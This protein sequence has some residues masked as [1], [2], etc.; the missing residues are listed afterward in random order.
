MVFGIH[1]TCNERSCASPTH[2][3]KHAPLLLIYALIVYSYIKYHKYSKNSCTF[4][5][6][7]ISFEIRRRYDLLCCLLVKLEQSL[8]CR[9]F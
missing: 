1:Y 6:F 5:A 7:Q 2:S 4:S 3:P 9:H 8:P